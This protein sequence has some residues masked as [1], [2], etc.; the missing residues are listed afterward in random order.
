MTNYSQG[1]QDAIY[2][3]LNVPLCTDI[4]T[5]QQHLLEKAQPP[6]FL[7]GDISLKPEGGKD[8]GLYL[9]T[10]QI[11]VYSRQPNRTQLYA[12]QAAVRT[13]L[14]YQNISEAGFLFTQPEEVK[15]EDSL[16]TDGQTYFGLQEF[17][18]FVQ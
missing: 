9:A 15:V 17:E 13:L 18:F 6:Y 12:M 14:N 8:G 5:V 7:I 11:W 2:S 1:A 10:A 16:L 4:A 3:A